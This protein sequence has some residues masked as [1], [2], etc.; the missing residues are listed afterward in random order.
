MKL[1]TCSIEFS[2]D[3]IMYRQL[4]GLGMGSILSSI[5]ANIFVGY[6]ESKL[7]TSD[8]NCKPE[9]YFRYVD[10]SF[11]AFYNLDQCVAFLNILN[12]LHPNLEFTMEMEEDNKL[13][14]L[15]VLVEKQDMM[16]VTSVFRK[17]TFT[18][19]YQ[20]WDS[21][22]PERIKINLIHMLVHRAM[23]ICSKSKLNGE[24][25]NIRQ[26]LLKNGYPAGVIDEN[27]REK[28]IKY[29]QGKQFGPKK[30]PTYLKLPY[31]GE[32]SAKITSFVRKVVN[33]TFPSVTLRT[34]FSSK[35]MLSTNHKDVLPIHQ[36]N[37]VIYKFQC[38]HCECAYIGRTTQRLGDRISQ[39]VPK[40]L[41]N[42][43]KTPQDDHTSCYNL[44]RRKPVSYVDFYTPSYV[45][46][47]IGMHLLENPSCAEVYEDFD[48]KILS[49]SRSSYQLNIL[50]AMYINSMKPELCRQK[51]F[52]YYC[53]LF[54]N[55]YKFDF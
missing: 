4:D 13:S 51:K 42:L 26:I 29:S 17:K 9:V 3:N 50:E 20:R 18:G 38:K 12:T 14:F 44:R 49:Q 48:F 24:L 6:L 22:S 31:L 32:R 5:L 54:A 15:D 11:A 53:R 25:D 46:S 16:I 19:Q 55:H 43:K 39:H 40:S 36:R 37:N 35:A 10:D 41:R 23:N 47:A 52:V 30:C 33:K 21:F 2:F 1:A 34:V 27:I 45:E 7:F 8:I 28:M